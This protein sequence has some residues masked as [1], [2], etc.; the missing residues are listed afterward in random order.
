MCSQM[1]LPL[2]STA[3]PNASMLMRLCILLTYLVTL[4]VKAN[5]TL[6]QAMKAQTASGSIIILIL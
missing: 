3:E 5:F 2:S 4:K 1:K 6:Q